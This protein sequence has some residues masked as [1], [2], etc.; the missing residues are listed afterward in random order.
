MDCLLLL[1]LILFT[2]FQ[3]RHI[4]DL[5]FVQLFVP[6]NIYILFSPILFI[7]GTIYLILYHTLTLWSPL[8]TTIVSLSLILWMY[9]SISCTPFYA[10]FAFMH[11]FHRKKTVHEASIPRSTEDNKYIYTH[12]VKVIS[13]KSH[14]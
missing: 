2:P 14:G 4:H 13:C 3:S 11:K 12:S 10:S 1:L 7:C 5:S 8:K 6:I 9:A